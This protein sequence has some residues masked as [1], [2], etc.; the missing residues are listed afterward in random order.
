MPDSP[1]N[2][3]IV[4]C[5]IFG[6]V[7]AATYRDFEHA[8]LVAV[9]DLDPKRAR[10]L[11]AKYGAR[12][13][14]RVEEIAE[15]P[16]VQ[17]VS[18]ATPDF[19]HR[20]VCEVLAAAGKHLLVEKPL[21]MTVADA[22]A[23]R[24]AVARAGVL[25]MVDFHNRY[26]PALVPIKQ[27]LERGELGRPQMMYGRLSDRLEVATEW[28]AWS[29]RS[30]PEWF[31]GSHLADVACWLFGAYPT[32]VFAQ[33]RKDVLASRGIGCYDSVQM[34]LAFPEGFATLETSWILPASWPT[35]VDFVVSLQT[36]GGRADMDMG[37]QGSQIA[38]AA[39][40]ER[41][42]L[43]AR[44]PLDPDDFGFLS[45]PIR[46]FVRAVLAGGES[47]MPLELGL[48]NVQILAA[49]HESLESG[50]PVAITYDAP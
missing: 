38:A 1:L 34:S 11:A 16:A 14:T 31:L 24:D 49:V 6:E 10:A 3:A 21:A 5:G 41:P 29:G 13:C 26:H 23:I 43:V 37:D 42:M 33:G 20:H 30:G 28:F 4:G 8:R 2:V 48:K 40:Y 12:A 47:P 44:D 22:R 19:A 32:R 25:G 45:L 7:H 18:V 50:A 35:L 27:R 15:D 46:R 36:T 17:A 39:G 9:C